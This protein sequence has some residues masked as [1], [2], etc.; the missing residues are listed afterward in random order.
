MVVTNIEIVRIPD[1]IVI[2]RS[3]VLF[4]IENVVHFGFGLIVFGIVVGG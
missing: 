4:V 3:M 2:L 1:V